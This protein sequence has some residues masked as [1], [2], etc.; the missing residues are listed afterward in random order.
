G[1]KT[2]VGIKIMGPDLSVL[3]NLAQ[4]V[5]QTIKSGQGVGEFTTSAFAEKSV[6]GHYLNIR[7]DRAAIARY[8]LSIEDV[9]N[10]IMTA[11]VVMKVTNPGEGQERYPVD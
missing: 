3:A 1:I 2:P 8:G 7:P 6:G 11:V 5:A 10:V 9:Q 4:Q